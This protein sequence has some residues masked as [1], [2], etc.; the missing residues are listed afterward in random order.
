MDATDAVAPAPLN[1]QLV[2]E[3]LV[4]R[5]VADLRVDRA[6]T[7]AEKA[8]AARR[9]FALGFGRASICARLGVP[10]RDVVLWLD[11]PRT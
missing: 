4:D 9:L 3:V 1:D 8:S 10:H 2:D 11:G 7:R 6:L 5:V